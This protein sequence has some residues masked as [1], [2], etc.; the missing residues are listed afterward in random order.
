MQRSALDAESLFASLLSMPSVY[1]YRDPHT[2]SMAGKQIGA[3]SILE[4]ARGVLIPDSCCGSAVCSVR[5]LVLATASEQGV[6]L[7]AT[8]LCHQAGYRDVAIQVT[9]RAGPFSAWRAA[10]VTVLEL[11]QT[12]RNRTA[13]CCKQ[14]IL[15]CMVLSQ[16]TQGCIAC[17]RLRRKN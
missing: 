7:E 6:L 9:P 14:C 2:W 11:P 1:G 8:R 5:L 10:N 16:L 3:M 4:Y 12:D 13:V 15:E 17:F